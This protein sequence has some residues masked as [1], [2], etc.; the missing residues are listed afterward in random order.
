MLFLQYRFESIKSI[1]KKITITQKPLRAANHWVVSRLV[2]VREATH[3]RHHAEHVV[4]RRVDVDRRGRRR[5]NRVVGDRQQERRVINARQV[6]R[7]R[8]LVLLGLERKRVHVD[9]NRGNVRVVLVRLHLVEIAALANLEPVVAVELQERRDDGVLARHALVARDG[10]A[11][12]EHR[13]VPPVR[14]VEGLLALPGVDRRIIAR[15]EGVTLHDPH[16][17]LARVVEVQLELVGRGR[18]GLT[19]RELEG[20]DQVLVRH[21]GELATLVRVEVDVVHVERGRRQ[22]RRRHTVADRVEVRGDLGR[23]VEAEVA[24]VVELE[25]DA[26]LVVL[27]RNEGQRKARVAAEPELQRDVERV[28]RGAVEDLGGR[29]GLATGAVIVARLAALDEEVRQLGRVADHL[30][31]ARLLARLLREL[32]PD[33]EPL[34][35]VLVDALAAD[36]ELDGLDKVVAH[37]VEPAELGARAVRGL[38]LDLGER[39]LEVD[40]VDQVTVALD[41]ARHTLAEARGAVEGVLNGLHGEV[42]VA[43]V[44]DLEEGNLGVAREVNILGAV[45][46]KLHQTTTSHFSLYLLQRKNFKMSRKCGK[47]KLL[48][49]A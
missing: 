21:L 47:R 6:A 13:A 4:V 7:A 49:E 42:R 22:V 32:I 15:D 5:A 40:A 10:V 31:V 8:R 1:H 30:G 27:Q 38:E 3:A 24:E 43:A 17:L 44:H 23:D 19:A 35:V 26:N 16:K 46:D 20:L 11:R 39:G 12:L 29:V 18:D 25:V 14:E 28:L 45:G 41:R 36:L 34:A 48:P 37:P 2:G 33:V 9:S